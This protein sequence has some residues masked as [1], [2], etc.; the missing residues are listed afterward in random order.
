MTITCRIYVEFFRCTVQ[1]VN[2]TF[3]LNI[4]TVV[5]NNFLFNVVYVVVMSYSYFDICDLKF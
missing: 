3:G 1:K 5:K 2:F 4:L